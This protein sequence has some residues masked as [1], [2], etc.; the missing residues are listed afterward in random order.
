VLQGLFNEQQ[1]QPP[2]PSL[3]ADV[4]A[5]S[6]GYS[7]AD[8]ELISY[9]SV[10]EPIAAL[11]PAL[12]SVEG[13]GRTLPAIAYELEVWQPLMQN[14]K[15]A[16]AKCPK[17]NTRHL[18]AVFHAVSQADPHDGAFLSWDPTSVL[19]ARSTPIFK[20]KN[21]PRKDF[22]SQVCVAFADPHMYAAWPYVSHL[23]DL[24]TSPT[25]KISPTPP[26][27]MAPESSSVGSESSGKPPAVPA[28]AGFNL[29]V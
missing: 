22:P 19:G 13:R 27:P 26:T 8:A 6:P 17:E 9:H 28:D 29:P 7:T 16:F 15:E 20:H 3:V 24:P 5:E 2:C 21:P 23:Y 10:F 18:A 14:I 12:A 1:V 25:P 11:V 4:L